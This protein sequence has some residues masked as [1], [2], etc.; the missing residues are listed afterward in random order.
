MKNILLGVFLLSVQLLAAQNAVSIGFKTGLTFSTIEGPLEMD[1]DGSVLESQNYTTGFNFGALVNFRLTDIFGLRTELLY[2]QK[3]TEFNYEGDSYFIFDPS[4]N[5]IVTTGQR[6]MVLEIT[7][8][9]IEI[10]LMA[11][12]KFGPVEFQGGAYVSGLGNATASGN[13]KYRPDSGQGA[14]V[15]ELEFNLDYNYYSNDPGAFLGELKLDNVVINGIR[16][17]VPETLTAYYESDDGD[18]QLFK[19]LDYG[20]VGGVAFYLSNGLFINLR[21]EYGLADI[22]NEERDVSLLKL[23]DGNFIYRDD[24]DRNLSLQASIGFRF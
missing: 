21:A 5:R 11:Y 12:A 4:N 17:D 6:D 8:S 2:I 7:N 15:E 9:Y 18:D 1:A 16:L 19:R 23:E 24:M 3:G 22:T 10:P 13:L 14:S 20:V